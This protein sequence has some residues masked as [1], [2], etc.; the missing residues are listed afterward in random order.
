MTLSE[1]YSWTAVGNCMQTSSSGEALNEYEG[2]Y[3]HAHLQVEPAKVAYSSSPPPSSFG[4]NQAK[5]TKNKIQE[6]PINMAFAFS[7]ASSSGLMASFH[8]FPFSSI[9]LPLSLLT[10]FNM[11]LSKCIYL[12]F[13]SKQTSSTESLHDPYIYS[14]LT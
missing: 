7:T 11:H 10:S 3:I 8:I 2:N 12:R 9:T 5:K 1:Q 13:P 14:K 6:Q 4:I